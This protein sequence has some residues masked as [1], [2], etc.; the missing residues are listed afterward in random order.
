MWPGVLTDLACVVVGGLVGRQTQDRVGTAVELRTRGLA[1]E[2]SE[3]LCGPRGD[4]RSGAG[5]EQGS[6][7]FAPMKHP[8]CCCFELFLDFQRAI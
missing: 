6:E 5:S 1:G 7:I 8:R 3:L 2:Q 4:G